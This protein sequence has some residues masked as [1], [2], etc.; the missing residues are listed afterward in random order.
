MSLRKETAHRLSDNVREE[1]LSQEKSHLFPASESPEQI[2]RILDLNVLD[3]HEWK[4]LHADCEQYRQH[5]DESKRQYIRSLMQ[6]VFQDPKKLNM[7]ALVEMALLFADDRQNFM[8]ENVQH[9]FENVSKEKSGIGKT[10]LQ[11]LLQQ[12]NL[13]EAHAHTPMIRYQLHLILDLITECLELIDIDS[14]E[15]AAKENSVPSHGIFRKEMAHFS[16]EKMRTSSNYLL[17]RKYQDIYELLHADTLDKPDA[18]HGVYGAPLSTYRTNARQ[19]RKSKIIRRN[20][21]IVGQTSFR[22]IGQ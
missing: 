22:C 6:T 3:E 14:F 7:Y 13:L 2:K 1:G 17:S 4:N 5:S 10:Q 15:K 12:L 11:N 9:I 21:H 19:S 8:K 18:L 20:P 16:T